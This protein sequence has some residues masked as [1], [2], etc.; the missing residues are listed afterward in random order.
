M[1][2]AFVTVGDTAR[3]VGGHLYNARVLAGLRAR[4]VEVEEIVASAEYVGDQ[5]AASPALGE[6][7][8]P[9]EFDVISV[10]ALARAACAPHL[11]R[12]RVRAPVVA[13][14][15]ELPSVAESDD[16]ERPLE[17]PLLRA[18]RLVCVS[19]HGAS[20]LEAR[21]VPPGRV[22]V[23]PPGLDRPPSLAP[24][25][26]GDDPLRVLCVAQWIPR[27]GIAR[28][29]EAW[30]MLRDREPGLD[31]VLELVGETGADPDYAA[32]V[33]ESIAGAEDIVVRGPV[34]EPE[35]RRAYATASAFAL[36]SFYEGYGMVYAE[37]MSYGLPVVALSTGPVPDLVGEAGLLVEP[38]DARGLANALQ[39][40]LTDAALRQRLSEAALLRAGGLPG[41]EDAVDGFL[42]ALEAAV[43]EK[44]RR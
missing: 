10:D 16:T 35:L 43:S 19:R 23:V 42:D 28:L 7:L 20:I 34:G 4:G 41:W 15:H 1:R 30:G 44:V 40:L 9:G 29:V 26:G 21:G 22:H 14:V 36:P 25:I 17:D 13:M 24:D 27:K 39:D 38:G 8:L 12:W 3:K 6:R 18:D 5:R 37:A 2:I 31:A 33:Y 11:D 32:R